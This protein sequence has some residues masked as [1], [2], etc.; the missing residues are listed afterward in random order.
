MSKP[1]SDKPIVKAKLT[2][3]I[4]M[5][6]TSG[7]PGSRNAPLIAFAGSENSNA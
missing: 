2:Y 4:C 5:A 6:L 7:Y 1:V 3:A